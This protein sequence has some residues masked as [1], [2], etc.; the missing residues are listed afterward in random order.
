[1]NSISYDF[2]VMWNEL[3]KGT[4]YDYFV[5]CNN[6]DTGFTFDS[7]YWY[8]Y[9]SFYK[10][11]TRL[12]FNIETDLSLN[13]YTQDNSHTNVSF[14]QKIKNIIKKLFRYDNVHLF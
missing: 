4:F 1:M 2:R 14:F 10:Y 5:E 13:I 12:N 7:R 6:I 8:D 3:V 9:G 11:G